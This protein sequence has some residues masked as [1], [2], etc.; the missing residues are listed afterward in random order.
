MS[1]APFITTQKLGSGWAAVHFWWN[2]EDYPETW[3][4]EGLGDMGFWE[5]MQSG[6]G[7]YATEQEAE[8]EARHWA[9]DEGIRFLARGEQP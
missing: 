6:I 7:R 5:P 1:T 4:A 2:T 9:E 3:K 8:L